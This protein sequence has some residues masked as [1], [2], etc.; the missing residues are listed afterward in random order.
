MVK[1]QANLEREVKLLRKQVNTLNERV[2]DRFDFLLDELKEI[3]YRNK[4]SLE[5]NETNVSGL[6][7]VIM[8]KKSLS[9]LVLPW[10]V[11]SQVI[12][13]LK[14]INNYPKLVK[15]YGLKRILKSNTI[16]L[17]FIGQPGTGKTLTAEVV[18][19]YLGKKLYAVRYSDLVE[20]YIG[21]T[22]KN[23][24]KVF[25][26]A[27]ESSA[28]LFF[29]EADAI[30]STRTIVMN[31]TDSENNL[32][33]NVLLKELENFNGVVI[34]ATNL[35]ENFDKAFERRI[36]MHI[37]F[38]MPDAPDRERLWKTLC[39]G[40]KIHKDVNFKELSRRY[41]FSG[42][43]IRNAILNAA[44]VALSYN[45]KSLTMEDFVKG[46]ELV[47]KGSLFMN[48]T[49]YNKELRYIG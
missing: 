32:I 3:G 45:K 28:V 36:H 39:R 4:F 21:E 47:E 44:R 1:S 18:A 41:N 10:D 12:M 20:S 16:A 7:S 9:D 30:A 29:D 42:G 14:Q 26:Y 23:I 8:P 33:R 35:A 48:G 46:S 19:K 2:R 49:S 15:G 17:N 27:R 38:K 24:V 37:L 5:K 11:E 43:N 40:L 22:S 6:V 31:A 13:A 25:N 34:F